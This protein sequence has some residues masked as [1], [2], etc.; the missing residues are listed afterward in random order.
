MPIGESCKGRESRNGLRREPL[1]RLK[2]VRWPE[3]KM[4]LV[5]NEERGQ[6]SKTI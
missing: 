1:D 2:G 3:R 6:G 4:Q 5:F